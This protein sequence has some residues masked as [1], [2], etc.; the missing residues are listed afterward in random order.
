MLIAEDLDCFF[1]LLLLA[2]VFIAL[3]AVVNNC[4]NGCLS[5]LV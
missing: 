5:G 1:L 4:H 2:L 3:V